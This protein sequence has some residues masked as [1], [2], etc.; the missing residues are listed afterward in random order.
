MDDI[1]QNDSYFP[2]PKVV[3]NEQ[4]KVLSANQY[5]GEVFLYE[6]IKG[7]D[8]FTLTGKKA[9][10]LFECAENGGHPLI[11]RNNKVFKIIA[12][13]EPG[14]ENELSLIFS[15]VTVLEDL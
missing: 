10:E 14:R 4:G 15:D 3:I 7:A 5:I 13:H 12:Y 6:G 8:I 11:E 1:K 2:G 9:G